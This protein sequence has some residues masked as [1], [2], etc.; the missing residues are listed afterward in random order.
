VAVSDENAAPPQPCKPAHA[1]LREAAVAG[2]KREWTDFIA[3]RM[4]V[5]NLSALES[6]ARG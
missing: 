4:I 6:F 3:I 5:V 2:K 1:T